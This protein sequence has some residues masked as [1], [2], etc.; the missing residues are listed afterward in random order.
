MAR[1][2]VSSKARGMLMTNSLFDI[3]DAEFDAFKA[4]IKVAVSKIVS[5]FSL[6]AEKDPEMGRS[7]SVVTN[8]YMDHFTSELIGDVLIGAVQ[9]RFGLDGADMA[10]L[11]MGWVDDTTVLTV[12]LYR[13]DAG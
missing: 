4:S 12:N 9:R 3:T 6:V 1:I 2:G 5:D 7:L 13:Y 10:D 11:E 8:G